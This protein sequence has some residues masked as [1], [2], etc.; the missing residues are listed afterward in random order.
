[1]F[2]TVFTTT[3]ERVVSA[4]TITA[5]FTE[6]FAAQTV[7]VGHYYSPLGLLFYFSLSFE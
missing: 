7:I 1:M 6:L 4:V 2:D 5:Q 3:E